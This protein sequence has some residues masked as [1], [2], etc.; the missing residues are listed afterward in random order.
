MNNKPRNR[1]KYSSKKVLKYCKYYRKGFCRFGD[2]CC[3]IHD[4]SVILPCP[5]GANCSHD[6]CWYSHSDLFFTSKFEDLTNEVEALTK[7]LTLMENR[8]LCEC[9]HCPTV[10][11]PTSVHEQSSGSDESPKPE[12]NI[13][14]SRVNQL[15]PPQR[16]YSQ[17]QDLD[18]SNSDNSPPLLKISTVNTTKQR[19]AGYKLKTEKEAHST[20]TQM[21]QPAETNILQ[22]TVKIENTSIPSIEE[23]HK[24]SAASHQE[25]MK[26]LADSVAEMRRY[27]AKQTQQPLK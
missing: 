2:R 22:S 1:V 10:I 5:Y 25:L 19:I 12:T 4:P 3:F 14:R 15:N 27:K 23:A 11:S 16:Q 18:S 24:A 8:K 9:H 7:R 21:Y 6:D 17:I 13:P 20:K 26:M